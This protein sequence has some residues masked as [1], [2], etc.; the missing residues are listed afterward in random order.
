[1]TPET[2]PFCVFCPRSSMSPYLRFM[3]RMHVG[4]Y[5]KCPKINC[6][7]RITIRECCNECGFVPSQKYFNFSR[8]R[9][10]LLPEVYKSKSFAF[11]ALQRCFRAVMYTV[12]INKVL[13][14]ILAERKLRRFAAFQVVSSF[15]NDIKRLIFTKA[16]LIR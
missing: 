6:T 2:D 10:C 16:N 15:P 7:G 9:D 3:Y 14:M 1:M 4:R 5:H 11:K 8:Y 12:L 13:Q